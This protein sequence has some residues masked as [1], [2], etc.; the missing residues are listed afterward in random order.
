VPVIKH[1]LK[2][3]DHILLGGIVGN[4]FQLAEG[5]DIGESKADAALVDVAQEILLIA[6]HP[7][8]ATV[9]I[10]QDVIVASEAKEDAI[11]LD[12]P[13]EDIE[14]DMQIYDIGRLTQ[15]EYADY[16]KH[17]KTII[18]NGPVG[19][20]SYTP[21]AGGTIAIAKAV[22]EATKNGAQSLLGGGDTLGFL[23]QHGINEDDFTHVSTG[24]GAMLQ[25]L[26]GKGLYALD[27]LK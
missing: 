4:T 1:F 22:V 7:S 16:I 5:F 3:A 8:T 11:A 13:V 15:Q 6:D 24:G 19:V 26:S 17:A 21:F 27:A 23:Q 10:P 25:Y 12:L 2:R 20:T 18:W 9:H 14:L